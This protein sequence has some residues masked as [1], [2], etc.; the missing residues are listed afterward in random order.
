[1]AGLT[2]GAPVL[3]GGLS[4]TF[5]YHELVAVWGVF[6]ILAGCMGGVELINPFAVP[7]TPE[8]I[9]IKR[10]WVHRGFAFLVL[11]LLAAVGGGL[12][13]ATT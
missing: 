10:R 5:R 2:V 13:L 7:P 12:L 9:Q 6:P 1:M 4:A 11:S 3:I 8:S